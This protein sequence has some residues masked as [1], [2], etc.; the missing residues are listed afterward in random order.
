MRLNYKFQGTGRP[1]VIVHGLFGMLDNWQSIARDLSDSFAVYTLD[2]RNHGRSGHALAMD[3]NMMAEDIA[4]FFEEHKISEPCLLGHSM[5]GKIAMQLALL[6]P[7][8]L[9]SLVAIDV[10]PKAY[11]P[12]HLEIMDT[13]RTA[14][15]EGTERRRDVEAQLM[16]S[17]GSL[18]VVR[19]L[20]KNLARRPE[21]GFEW[22]MNLPV[23]RKYYEDIIGGLVLDGAFPGPSLFVRGDR[24]EYILDSDWPGILQNFPSAELVTIKDAGHWVHADQPK[25]LLSNLRRFLNA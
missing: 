11:A 23:I 4:E 14:N 9:G 13:L 6:Q 1:I 16:Q 12:G 25:A 22:K 10:A 3:Y 17:L 2:A 24:S 15:I 20:M 8:L 5:G 21:G 18:A 7:G 19:F